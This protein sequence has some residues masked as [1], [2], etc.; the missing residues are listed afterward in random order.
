MPVKTT[1]MT[2]IRKMILANEAAPE[3]I[4]VKPK[5]AAIIAITKN[6]AVNFNIVIGFK[7]F[8]K[9]QL[10]L[11]FSMLRQSISLYYMLVVDFAWF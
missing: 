4:S 6:T 8:R 5:N 2:K 1:N 3:A 10:M 7:Y 11:I 9:L